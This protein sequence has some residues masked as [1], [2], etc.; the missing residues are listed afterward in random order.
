MKKILPAIIA[1]L[2]VLPMTAAL[3]GDGY[4]RV[5]NAKTKRYAYLTDNTGHINMATTS[6]DVHALELWL[7]FENAVSDPATVFMI[8]NYP[9]TGSANNYDVA[10]QGT[11]VHS[12]LDTYLKIL[13]AG[14]FDGKP[15]YYAYAQK[16]G[17]IKYLGDLRDM[18]LTNPQGNASVDCK[19]DNRKWYITPLDSNDDEGYFGVAPTVAKDGKYYQ[20]FYADFP[21]TVKS[22]G[23]KVYIVDRLIEGAAVLKELSG[24]VPARTPVI[25]ECEHQSASDNRLDIGASGTAADVSGN[26]LGGV[27]YDNSSQSHYNRTPYDKNTMRSIAVVDGKLSFVTGDYDFIPRNR[28]YLNVPAGTAA[29][30]RLLKEDEIDAYLQEMDN[31]RNK[32]S[33]ISFDPSTV[34]VERG[35]SLTLT[36]VTTPANPSN[37]SLTWSS[38][39]PSIATVAGGVVSGLANG[40]CTVTATSDN[41]ITGTVTVKVIKSAESVTLDITEVSL[42]SQETAQLTATLLPEDVTETSLKW[43]SSDQDVAVVSASGVVRARFPGECDITVTTTNG[44]TAVCHVTSG[45]NGIAEVTVDGDA[46]IYDLEGHRV[47]SMTSGGVYI[48]VKDGKSHKMIIK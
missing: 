20:P 45:N 7:G 26:L 37:P 4:Y 15:S 38:S 41:G 13:S 46:E 2:S 35:E 19:G 14:D 9:N 30:I 34:K 39:D 16:S 22:A 6:A 36:P 1:V 18:D 43:T 21:F 5:Q 31:E 32:I 42:A 47:T 11:S 40:T 28:A 23:V 44:L 25:F 8:T 12:F 24:Y 3:Q 10:G 33:A 48:V 29:G 17:M 27:F